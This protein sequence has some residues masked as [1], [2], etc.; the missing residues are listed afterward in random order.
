[1]FHKVHQQNTI[2]RG[3]L[4]T[5]SVDILGWEKYFLLYQV[6]EIPSGIFVFQRTEHAFSKQIK[7]FLKI[8][9]A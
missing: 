6:T 5:H 7:H 4:C 2:S 1:M 8:V 9:L 3:Q